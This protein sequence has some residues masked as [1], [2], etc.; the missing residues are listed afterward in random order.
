MNYFRTVLSVVILSMACAYGALGWK[1]AVA[2]EPRKGTEEDG[3]ERLPKDVLQ[4]HGITTENAVRVRITDLDYTFTKPLVV[5]ILV[6]TLGEVSARVENR[7][8]HEK[9]GGGRIAFEVEGPSKA[10]A[11]IAFALDP[12][13]GP[14]NMCCIMGLYRPVEPLPSFTRQAWNARSTPLDALDKADF[15]K[16]RKEIRS[17]LT[18]EELKERM[19]GKANISDEWKETSFLPDELATGSTI[20]LAPTDRLEA[21]MEIIRYCEPGGIESIENRDL[22]AWAYN[23]ALSI[24]VDLSRWNEFEPTLA[25]YERLFGSDLRPSRLWGSLTYAQDAQLKAMWHRIVALDKQGRRKEALEMKLKSHESWMRLFDQHRA[26]LTPSDLFR[27]YAG[28]YWRTPLEIGK[29]YRELGQ[30]EEALAWY[31]KVQ[32]HWADEGAFRDFKGQRSEEMEKGEKDLRNDLETRIR[33]FNL[34]ELPKLVAEC[35][36]KAKE[37]KQPH[38]RQ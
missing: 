17:L 21:W 16:L 10:R 6:R 20:S 24:S 27:D 14:G 12:R 11:A 35:E 25:A 23:E 4:A 36:Q 26:K 2:G 32:G 33:K 5:K 30:Y 38:D 18:A 37:T 9:H 13:G 1:I 29:R 34:D 8:G 28:F 3:M 31:R 15:E 22:L 19:K 7:A